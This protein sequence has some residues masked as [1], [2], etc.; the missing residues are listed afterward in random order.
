[1]QP[2]GQTQIPANI[3][4]GHVSVVKKNHFKIAYLPFE[5][6][7]NALSFSAYWNCGGVYTSLY[8]KQGALV[9][10]AKTLIRN[11]LLF[12]DVRGHICLV[13]IL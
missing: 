11:S 12:C 3:S 13:A 1:M 10:V 2:R 9:P 6:F 4:L 7:S 5:L 8:T